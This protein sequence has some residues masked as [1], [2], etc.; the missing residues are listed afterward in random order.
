MGHK[1]LKSFLRGFKMKITTENFEKYLKE[2][3]IEYKKENGN[4]TVGDSLYLSGTEITALPETLTVGGSLNLYCTEIMALPENLTVGG[5]LDLSGTNIKKNNKIQKPSSDFIQDFYRKVQSKLQWQNGKYRKIDGVF[6]EVLKT[7]RNVM[8]VKVGTKTAYIFTKNEVSAHGD[9][10]RQAYLDWLFKTSDRDVSQYADIQQ[11]DVK[12]LDY[13]VIAYRTI[14]GA[15]S[16]GTNEYLEKNK[17]KYKAQ[18]TLQEVLTA[19]VGQYGHNTFA[20]FFKA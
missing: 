12:P 2:N 4:L 8:Q 6:C 14:T 19:T 16:F 5:S 3:D 10:A 15:C 11:D 7:C 13:W 1:H 17:D 18:M 9:T 20:E